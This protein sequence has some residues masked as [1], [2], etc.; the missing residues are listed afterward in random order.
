MFKFSKAL[1]LNS[2]AYA[3][4]PVFHNIQRAIFVTCFYSRQSLLRMS[5]CLNRRADAMLNARN[6]KKI[7]WESSKFLNR[8]ERSHLPCPRKS[9]L[10]MPIWNGLFLLGWYFILCNLTFLRCGEGIEFHM[11]I[12]TIVSTLAL[13][14][15]VCAC[16][17]FLLHERFGSWCGFDINNYILWSG[18]MKSIDVLQSVLFVC[19]SKDNKMIHFLLEIE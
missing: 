17:F 18:I 4:T 9:H 16:S 8:H 15:C 7:M 19:Q 2:Q 6:S 5:C 13:Y 11:I 10:V 12:I 3:N 14:L 1:K